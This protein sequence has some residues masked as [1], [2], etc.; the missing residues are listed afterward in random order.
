MQT[1]LKFLWAEGLTKEG[2]GVIV[3]ELAHR[4]GQRVKEQ[5]LHPHA[6]ILLCK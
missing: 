6:V 4:S 2:H 1:F 3:Q 5:G